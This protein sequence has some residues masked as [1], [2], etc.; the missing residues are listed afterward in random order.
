MI[1]FNEADCDV[2]QEELD[3]SKKRMEEFGLLAN[4]LDRSSKEGVVVEVIS[5][6]TDFIK[7]GKS[8]E[9]AVTDA[10]YAWDCR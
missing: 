6:Y 7:E 5:T 8:V 9:E 1:S 10:L 2:T 4:M 3:E